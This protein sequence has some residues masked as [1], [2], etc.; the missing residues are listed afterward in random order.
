MNETLLMVLGAILAIAGGFLHQMY[1]NS[2]TNKRKDREL[3]HQAEETLKEMLPILDNMPASREELNDP[4][5][6][7][8]SIAIRIWVKSNLDLAKRM[9]EFV[10]KDGE[11]TED[12]A[13]QLLID[14]ADRIGKALDMF[15][16]EQ[17]ELFA[18]AGEELKQ[19]MEREDKAR[20][21]NR[22]ENEKKE[23]S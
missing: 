3:L 22:G 14:I 15:H 19:R 1:Q 5:K 6:K 10:R 11:K 8:F 7:L 4:C 21:K 12:K 16:K 2:L 23:L 20:Q 13:R 9:I 17:N 18:K